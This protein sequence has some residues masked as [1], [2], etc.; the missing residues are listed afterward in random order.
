MPTFGFN[1]VIV[2]CFIILL[3]NVLYPGIEA[4]SHERTENLLNKSFFTPIMII[5]INYYLQPPQGTLSV[6]LY[7]ATPYSKPISFQDYCSF[8]S[9]AL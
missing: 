6:F 8:Y 2:Y 9:I 1:V 3:I 7:N 5:N 4:D